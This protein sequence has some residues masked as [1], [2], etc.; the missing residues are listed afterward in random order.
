MIA[1]GSSEVNIS[2]LITEK[3]VQRA[4]RAAHASFGLGKPAH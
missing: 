4:V 3:D 1:Q 2:V